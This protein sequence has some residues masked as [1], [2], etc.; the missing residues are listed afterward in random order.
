MI[1]SPGWRGG[2]DAVLGLCPDGGYWAIGMN[3]SQPG[4]FDGVP[5]STGRTGEIQ[6]ERLRELGLTVGMLPEVCDIDFFE[7][8]RR[9]AAEYPDGVF[10]SAVRRM[11]M[12]LCPN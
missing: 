9:V 10:A 5:M 3:E 2:E 8:A 1:P 6:L 11:E 7:D 4:A 12:N